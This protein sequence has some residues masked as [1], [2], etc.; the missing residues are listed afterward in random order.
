VSE[1][2]RRI[3]STAAGFTPQWAS[4]SDTWFAW[5]PVFTGALG[6]I[7]GGRLVWLRRVYRNRC[8]GVTIYQELP[9]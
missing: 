6:M 4:R 9:R 3:A 8:M 7:G 5:R 1:I 2:D